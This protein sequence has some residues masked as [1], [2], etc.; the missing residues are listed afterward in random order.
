MDPREERVAWPL[1]PPS[2]PGRSLGPG[3]VEVGGMMN[4]SSLRREAGFTLIELM[5][6]VAIIGVLASIAVP[7][8]RN[9]QL[10][11]KRSEAYANLAGLARAQKS[12][13]AEF[14]TYVPSVSQPFGLTGQQPESKKRSSANWDTTA[15]AAVGWEP[16]GDVF[17][18]YDTNANQT[19]ADANCACDGCFTATA[20]GDL[21]GDAAMSVITYGSPNNAGALCATGLFGF[22]PPASD[23]PVV[24]TTTDDF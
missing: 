12:Y 5:I 4:V 24:I 15:F 2:A 17:Y 7:S 6:V 19:P 16:E 3:L 21:D 20:Y 11:S 1:L 9:Y 8:F 10:R 23:A 22:A 18:D 13:F 14:N